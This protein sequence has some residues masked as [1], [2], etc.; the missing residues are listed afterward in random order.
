MQLFE[1]LASALITHAENIASYFGRGGTQLYRM[2][3]TMIK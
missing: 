2:P 1:L 3:Y